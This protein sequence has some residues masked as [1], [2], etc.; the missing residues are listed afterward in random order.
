[1]KKIIITLV[2][3]L[4]ATPFFAQSAFDKFDGQDDVTSIVVNRKMFDLMSKVK[5]DASDKETQQYMNLIK[6]LDNLKVFTTSNSRATGE[7]K[8]AAEKYVKTAG[9]EELMRVNDSGKNI[10][11]LVKSGATDSQIK[12]LL[13]FIE[14]G[15]RSNETVLMSLTGNFDLNEISILT[16]KMRIPGGDELK[17]ATKGKK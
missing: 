5:V 7:M 16:D 10:K 3:A 6:K 12:E 15:S 14:G 13:M 4:I 8:S 2:I 1:M 17:K 9:L 11:I